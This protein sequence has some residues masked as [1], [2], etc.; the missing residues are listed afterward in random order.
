M[1][2]SEYYAPNYYNRIIQTDLDILSL[3]T[4]KKTPDIS[5]GCLNDLSLFDICLE[6]CAFV[7]FLDG[8]SELFKCLKSVKDDISLL[9]SFAVYLAEENITVGNFYGNSAEITSLAVIRCYYV[10]EKSV[11]IICK[12]IIVLLSFG[13]LFLVLRLCR[14]FS[15]FLLLIVSSCCSCLFLF[16]LS[17]CGSFLGSLQVQLQAVIQ[18][19]F[20]N[21]SFS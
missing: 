7:V 9:K 12:C 5:I 18:L 8:I 16:L 17:L 13:S 3:Y 10:L 11:V 4:D 19:P 14:C 21:S 20:S 1:F 2:F 15:F 6:L